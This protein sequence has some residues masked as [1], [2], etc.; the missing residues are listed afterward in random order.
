[1]T[2]PWG[3]TNASEETLDLSK[4]T[5]TYQKEPLKRDLFQ[6]DDALCCLRCDKCVRTALLKSKETNIYKK[7]A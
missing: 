2:T 6:F 5:Y 7:D 1:M 4:E 3:A